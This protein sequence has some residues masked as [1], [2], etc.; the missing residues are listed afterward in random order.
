M[1]IGT[2]QTLQVG[3][4]HRYGTEGAEHSMTRPWETSFFRT[5]S[6]QPRWL[7]T[8]HLEGN[9][10][11]D[12]KNHGQ[13]NQAILLY[14]AAHYPLW[15]TELDRPE[16]G[17]GGFGENAT[18]EDLSEATTCVGDVYAIG[19]VRIRVEGPRYPCTKIERRWNLPGLTA[20][21][22]ATGRTGWYC[23]VL[24]EGLLKPG[25][26][27][28]LD[29]RP[30]PAWTM[31]LINDFGHF[32]NRDLATAEAIA[33]CPLLDPWWQRLVVRRAQGHEW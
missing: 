12:T 15:R 9:A 21:V 33:A 16:I 19:D 7:F 29:E 8:T 10:Q 3:T 17:P 13:L 25:L 22:A 6:D 11:A 27:I 18:V 24:Q 5:P 4:P 20:R 28:T 30:Y 31:S 1:Q 23:S 2:I 26:P 32:R 14:A